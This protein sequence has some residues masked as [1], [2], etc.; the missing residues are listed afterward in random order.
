MVLQKKGLLS[1][2][3]QLFT[4]ISS[5]KEGNLRG[6]FGSFS[7]ASTTGSPNGMCKN[8]PCSNYECKNLVCGNGECK[9][10]KCVNEGCFNVTT[11]AP[12]ATTPEPK[13]GFIP[14]G[15]L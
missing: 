10:Y 7:V 5:D 13:S 11:K 12:D 6:G 2:C 4:P 9:N 1:D 15:F 3:E 14:C 8:V